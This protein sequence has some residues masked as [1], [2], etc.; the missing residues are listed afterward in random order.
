M[1]RRSFWRRVHFL[2][3]MRRATADGDGKKN[4][5]IQKS[6]QANRT[7]REIE[8][9]RTMRCPRRR[10]RKLYRGLILDAG[11]SWKMGKKKGKKEATYFIYFFFFSLPYSQ[12]VF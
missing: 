6:K 10:K 5:K 9:E 12:K 3:L 4:R 8:K 7:W 1:P 11:K 2:C